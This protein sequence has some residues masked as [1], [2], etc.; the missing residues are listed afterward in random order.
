MAATRPNDAACASSR[1]GAHP[2]VVLYRHGRRVRRFLPT[3]LGRWPDHGG[4]ARRGRYLYPVGGCRGRRRA[5]P[6]TGASVLKKALPGL[7]RRRWEFATS[8]AAVVAYAIGLLPS[9][10]AGSVPALS[11]W[12]LA[13]VGL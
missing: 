2:F 9:T 1:F 12:S 7:N 13:V 11:L 8:V 10:F 4:G 5:G 6:G 3:R